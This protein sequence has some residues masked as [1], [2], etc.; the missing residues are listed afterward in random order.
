MATNCELCGLRSNEVKSSTGISDLGTK[1]TLK[2]TDSSDLSRDILKVLYMWMEGEGRGENMRRKKGREG[3]LFG[4]P[5]ILLSS[6]SFRP[7]E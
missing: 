1:I 2:L 7:Q 5:S 4:L 6:P 3:K